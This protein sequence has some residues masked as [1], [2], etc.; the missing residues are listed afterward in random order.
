MNATRKM[1]DLRARERPQGPP[2]CVDCFTTQKPHGDLRC[3][4]CQKKLDDTRGQLAK[5]LDEQVGNLAGAVMRE[6]AEPMSLSLRARRSIGPDHKHQWQSVTVIVQACTD[7]V[8]VDH[9]SDGDRFDQVRADRC[10]LLGHCRHIRSYGIP[11]HECCSC[12]AT[13]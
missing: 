4:P 13:L 3:P 7:C 10:A 5:A 11:D 8:V 9:G 1:P 6:A 12:G 2:A